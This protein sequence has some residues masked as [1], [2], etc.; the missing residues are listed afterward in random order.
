MAV[1]CHSGEDDDADDG[2]GDDDEGED[3]GED[4]DD[5]ADSVADDN[6]YNDDD[7]VGCHDGFHW[8]IAK[9]IRTEVK[10]EF[11]TFYSNKKMYSK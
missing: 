6:D 3:D 10:L 7:R 11:A 9:Y 5:N 2:D 8:L 1:N 4:V